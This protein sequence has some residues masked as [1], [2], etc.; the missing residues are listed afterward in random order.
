MAA[1]GHPQCFFLDTRYAFSRDWATHHERFEA[2]D[3]SH[4]NAYANRV[5]ARTLADFI[6][7]KGLLDGP[8]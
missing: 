8:M 2:A 1:R 4:W 6:T 3:G 7:E 5:V